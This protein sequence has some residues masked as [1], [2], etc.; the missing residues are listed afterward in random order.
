MKLI[1]AIMPISASSVVDPSPWP[2]VVAFAA[3]FTVFGLVLYKHNFAP[4]IAIS[5]IKKFLPIIFLFRNFIN[6]FTFSQRVV[7][8]SEDEA[9]AGSSNEAHAAHNAYH[10]PLPR[11]PVVS[12]TSLEWYGRERYRSNGS[13]WTDSNRPTNWSFSHTS[14]LTP[15][16]PVA[17]DESHERP[18]S[19]LLG[20]GVWPETSAQLARARAR[21]R[22]LA[23]SSGEGELERASAASADSF[24]INRGE[25]PTVTLPPKVV[26]YLQKYTEVPNPPWPPCPPCGTGQVGGAGGPPHPPNPPGDFFINLINSLTNIPVGEKRLWGVGLFFVYKRVRGLL[27]KKTPSDESGSVNAGGPTEQLPIE[28]LPIEVVPIETVLEVVQLIET[29]KK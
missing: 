13:D 20:S 28:Q 23:R 6:P 26:E 18:T 3:F 12:P 19:S 5:S 11:S 9:S 16:I 21:A 17:S 29:F 10:D 25:A 14:W 1:I 4:N 7:P 8:S 22:A 15:T 27:T 24:P 2:F